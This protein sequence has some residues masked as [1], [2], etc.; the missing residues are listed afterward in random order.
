MQGLHSGMHLR[1][2]RQAGIIWLKR[3]TAL[4]VRTCRMHG[5][6]H[7]LR[8]TSNASAAC[9]YLPAGLVSIGVW[10]LT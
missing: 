4:C 10:R 1:I 3:F 2:Q 7:G 6:L 9:L 5:V 8:V